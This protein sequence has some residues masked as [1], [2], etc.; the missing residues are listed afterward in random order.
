MEIYFGGVMQGLMFLTAVSRLA[1]AWGSGLA[2]SV[3]VE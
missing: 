1:D 3:L 2:Y